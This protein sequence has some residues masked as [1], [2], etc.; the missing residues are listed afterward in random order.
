[1]FA[2]AVL[3]AR[4]HA[5]AAVRLRLDRPARARAATLA[6]SPALGLLDRGARA[7]AATL[8]ASPALG[9]LDRVRG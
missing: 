5:R 6:A 2:T 3:R 1:M 8:A 9:F 7:R 4:D